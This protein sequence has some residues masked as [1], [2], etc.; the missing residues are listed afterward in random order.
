MLVHS[1]GSGHDRFINRPKQN[2]SVIS[3]PYVNNIN[4]VDT[5]SFTGLKPEIIKNQF[6][7]LLSQDIWATKLA[8]KMPESDLEREALLELLEHRAKLDRYTRLR[9]EK[10][11]IITQLAHAERLLEN[12]PNSPELA[13]VMKELE[14]RGNLDSVLNT[15]EKQIE[16]EAKRNKPALDYFDG[17]AKLEEEYLAKKLVKGSQIEKFWHKIKKGN[18]NADGQYSTPQL[19]EIVKTGKL[20]RAVEEVVSAAP[21]ISSKKDLLE[22]VRA[23]YRQL[24]REDVNVYA[25]S[26]NHTPFAKHAQAKVQEKYDTQIKRFGVAQNRLD[27]IYKYVEREFNAQVENILDVDI[28]P[29]G[30]HWGQMSSVETAL[31]TLRRDIAQLRGRLENFPDEVDSQIRLAQKISELEA[32]KKLWILGMKKSVQYEAVN[33][34]MMEAAGKVKHYDYLT[35]ENKIIKL[36]KQALEICEQNNDELPE[37]MWIKILS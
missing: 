31:R 36:H 15:M 19:I 17:L 27:D 10:L 35:G 14:K 37:E 33:R 28:Y 6:K 30:E 25:T 24:L 12:S 4:S 16:K 32:T 18:I 5:V 1:V 34:E 20:P 21:R 2:N 8:V 3:I 26:N 11:E 22:V 9:N 7:I 13:A 23:E 29:M